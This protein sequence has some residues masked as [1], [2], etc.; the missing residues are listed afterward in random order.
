MSRREIAVW[1]GESLER[2]MKARDLTD[3]EIGA[4]CGVA[5]QT[6]YRWRQGSEPRGMQTLRDLADA[7]DV[8]PEEFF[9]YR[10]A[11]AARTT[12]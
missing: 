11:E 6:V 10:P 8:D 5:A 12:D 3:T 2:L 4:A 9:E 7:L 1:S